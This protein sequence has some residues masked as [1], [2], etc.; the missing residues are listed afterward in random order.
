MIWSSR[1]FG[2]FA[3]KVAFIAASTC[4]VAWSITALS[5]AAAS[6]CTWARIFA[7]SFCTSSEDAID[8]TWLS[9]SCTLF[10]PPPELKARRTV[11]PA[12]VA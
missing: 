3:A 2:S 4:A 9:A 12:C 7:Q 10:T 1:S 6:A 5:R 8:C 11:A